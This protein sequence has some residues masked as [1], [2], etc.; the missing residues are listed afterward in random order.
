MTIERE[1][2]DQKLQGPVSHSKAELIPFKYYLGLVRW[3]V[4]FPSIPTG[5]CIFAFDYSFPSVCPALSLGLRYLFNE[6]FSST[7]LT[8]QKSIL[9]AG[10]WYLFS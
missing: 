8:A 10:G 3:S 9:E 6:R 4:H 1:P 2:E 5:L 7:I